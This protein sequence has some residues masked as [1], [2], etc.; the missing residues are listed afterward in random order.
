M[1]SQVN[2]LWIYIY[3]YICIYT[4]IYIYIYIYLFIYIHVENFICRKRSGEQVF[5]TLLLRADANRGSD[6]F[7]EF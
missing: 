5:I 4:V 7:A 3:I 1:P 2:L 6:A